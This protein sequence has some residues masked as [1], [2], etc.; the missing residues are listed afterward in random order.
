[1]NKKIKFAVVGF[2]HIGKRHADLIVKNADAELAAICDIKQKEL[3]R[4][5]NYAVPFYQSI[6]DLLH[7]G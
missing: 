6:E 4:L 3:L 5:E 2:G 1:M 7:S